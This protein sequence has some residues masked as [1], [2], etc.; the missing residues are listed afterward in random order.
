M[1]FLVEETGDT[2][3]PIIVADHE[4]DED[5]DDKEDEE[6]TGD[7]PALVRVP[8]PLLWKMV[9]CTIPKKHGNFTL[10]PSRAFIWSRTG[11]RR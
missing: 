1:P 7:T 8:N 5:E 4:N 2:P 6:E 9:G 3:A 10:D 11:K